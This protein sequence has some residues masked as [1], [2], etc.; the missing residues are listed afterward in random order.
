MRV[1]II[2]GTK[3]TGPFV[4]KRLTGMGH[5]VTAFHRGQSEMASS[6]DGSELLGDRN[7]F[8]A[9]KGSIET[10]KPD[11]VL[12][13]VLFTVDQAQALQIAAQGIAKRIVAVSGIDVYQEYARLHNAGSS[14]IE[15]ELI[16]EESPLLSVDMPL[17]TSGPRMHPWPDA[18]RDMIRAEKSLL[19]MSGLAGTLLRLPLTYGVND[20]LHNLRGDLQRIDDGRPAIIVQEDMA[21][22]RWSRGYVE[23][24]AEAIA[25]A[26]DN[27]GAAG[28]VYN[29]ADAHALTTAQWIE[30]IGRAAGWQGKVVT[31]P[32]DE[33]PEEMQSH[34]DTDQHMV[35]DTKRI[36][37][38]LGYKDVASI[39]QA[40]AWS[41]AW[42]RANPPEEARAP[43][44]DYTIEDRLLEK[45]A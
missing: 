8:N 26:V 15:T 9:L 29:V 42:E 34:A 16:S 31:V 25:L 33:L 7:D 38:E 21:A 17:V 36:R 18:Q 28:K 45:Y 14:T 1:M 6:L 10:C 41:V 37:S 35:V 40:L 12:D 3:F 4:I 13:M 22:W 32:V 20:F 2:G 43:A 24:M 27:N 23:N 39:D 44:F 30:A 5:D 19:E 11:V